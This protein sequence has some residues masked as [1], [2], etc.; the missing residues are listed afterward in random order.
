M[1]RILIFLAFLLQRTVCFTVFPNSA[2]G[3]IHLRETENPVEDAAEEDLENAK[4]EVFLQKKFPTFHTLIND[5]M[6][7]AMKEGPVTIFAPNDAAFEALGE[8]KLVQLNDPR[9]L[10]I[11]EKLAS[12]HLIPGESIS[13]I[14]LRTEDWTKRPKDGSKPNTVIAAV[15]TLSGEVPVGR[16]KS[17]GFLGFGGKEDG[18]IVVGPDANIVGSFMVDDNMI[19]EMDGLVSPEVLWRYLDQLRIPGF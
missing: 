7:K 17:G 19:H 1:G 13:A 11:Q 2:R 15:K 5:G 3:S 12:F 18:E 16:R 6:K 8:K 14:E 4:L 9:N 10:E